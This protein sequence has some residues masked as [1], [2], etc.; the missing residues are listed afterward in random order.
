MVLLLSID[1]S[2][3]IVLQADIGWITGHSYCVYG[4]LL[5]LTWSI[6]VVFV[7]TCTQIHPPPL[8]LFK[9]GPL[10]NGSTSVM[11]SSTPIY[12]DHGRY[13]DMVER[14]K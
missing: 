10:I 9:L 14:H 4:E 11:F 12:P 2:K 7:F 13:W 3:T 6:V 8:L 1:V 5:P